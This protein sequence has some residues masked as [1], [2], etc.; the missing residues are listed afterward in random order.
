MVFP[1]HNFQKKIN[2]GVLDSQEGFEN[3][4]KGTRKLKSQWRTFGNKKQKNWKMIF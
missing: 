1:K 4:K 3:E 2:L